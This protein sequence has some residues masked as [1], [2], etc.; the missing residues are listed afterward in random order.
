[1]SIR[2]LE[3]RMNTCSWSDFSVTAGNQHLEIDL[4]D[5]ENKQSLGRMSLLE[6]NKLAKIR[7]LI[8]VLY[9][10]S[11]DPPEVRLMNGKRLAE[12]RDETRL[13]K[14]RELS[15]NKI[16]EFV[17]RI[18]SHIDQ[19]D[20]STKIG[21]AKNAYAKGS[22]IRFLLDFGRSI[23]EKEKEELVRDYYLNSNHN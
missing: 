13:I 10:E 6:A 15:N 20:L 2:N 16:D 4:F 5:D 21:Q 7:Q 17:V 1:M 22:T 19:N 18:R 11:R 8:L 12:I 3:R 9:D 23:D 14:K